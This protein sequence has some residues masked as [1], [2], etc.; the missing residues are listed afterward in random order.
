MCP[1][2][3]VFGP[4]KK[5]KKK[6]KKRRKNGGAGRVVERGHERESEKGLHNQYG[7]SR[8]K[9]KKVVKVDIT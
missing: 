1:I 4:S 5:K 9:H 3:I 8:R 6:E 7:V 2:A